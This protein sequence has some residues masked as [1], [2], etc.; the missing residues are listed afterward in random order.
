MT[1]TEETRGKCKISADFQRTPRSQLWKRTTCGGSALGNR[2]YG[3]V[4]CIQIKEK[5]DVQVYSEGERKF[6]TYH[7]TRCHI[8]DLKK[9]DNEI[10]TKQ[11]SCSFYNH[12]K[13]HF[14]SAANRAERSSTITWKREGFL[15]RI[16]DSLEN[17]GWT[18]RGSD[19]E[20]D[21]G[22]RTCMTW[23]HS[24]GRVHGC[25][26][27]QKG[28]RT[29]PD[30]FPLKKTEWNLMLYVLIK[31]KKKKLLLMYF[32]SCVLR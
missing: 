2:G 26:R 6:W 32:P 19:E 11:H 30:K 25:R 17:A 9:R 22:K 8:L 1:H 29:D 14:A 21:K 3:R 4:E 27:K 13:S 24:P 31:L 7:K 16:M 18:G 20:E 28:Q 12:P 15:T 5:I 10:L 23:K